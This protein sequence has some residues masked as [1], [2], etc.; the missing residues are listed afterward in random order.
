MPVGSEQS[1]PLGQIAEEKS[2]GYRGNAKE[3]ESSRWK[4]GYLLQPS[5]HR[6]RKSGVWQS[7]KNQNKAY[8]G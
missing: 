7:L 2:E 4:S 8:Q 3:S 1:C 6:F 5:L